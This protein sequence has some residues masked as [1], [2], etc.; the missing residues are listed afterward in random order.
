MTMDTTTAQIGDILCLIS[1]ASEKAVIITGA[2]SGIGR[3]L[4]IKLAK[5]GAKV[6]VGI[7]GHA[8]AEKVAVQIQHEA[9]VSAGRIVGYNLDLS[10]LSAV[11]RFADQIIKNEQRVDILLNNA[12]TFRKVHLLTTDSFEIQ[13]GINRGITAYFLHPDTIYRT[14]P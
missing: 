6:I 5:L 3:V 1:N 2:A 10:D 13:F 7:R 8:R 14:I 9:K 11:K 4:P 12:A